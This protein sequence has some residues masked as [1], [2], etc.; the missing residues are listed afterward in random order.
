MFTGLVEELGSV[1]K[2]ESGGAAGFYLKIR[3]NL[4]MA[5]LAVGDSVAVNGVCLTVTSLE[6]N[7]FTAD[8]M[9]ETMRKTNLYL[10]KTDEKVN[11]ER[12]LKADG[13]FGGHIVSGHIDGTG[14][15]LSRTR[16]GNAFV[17]SF[18]AP[19][20]IM[21]QTVAKGSI[22]VDGISLT[23]AT[24]KQDSFSVGIIP[25]TAAA[26]T[27]G[28]KKTGD[29]V[30]LEGDIIAKYVR[31]FMETKNDADGLTLANLKEKGYI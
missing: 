24:V 30:N 17:F 15:I 12:S 16:E 27:L 6:N 11:L 8:V 29:L 22:A 10:L 14:R 28:F 18:S 5:E 25:H 20:E 21:L 3:G 7:I 23:V 19:R 31:K 26:T 2:K 13:R 1:I 4:I 9:P